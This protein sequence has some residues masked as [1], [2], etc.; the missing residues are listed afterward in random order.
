MTFKIKSGLQVGSTTVVDQNSYYQQ[1]ESLSTVS[2]SL[3]LDF[4]TKTLDKRISFTRASTATVVGPNKLVQYVT[5][6]TPRFD[7]DPLTGI[8]NGL[9]I[10]EQKTNYCDST[11]RGG[12]WSIGNV[13][14]YFGYPSP[15][16][17]YNAWRIKG[18]G[19]SAVKYLYKQVSYAANGNFTF[20]IYAKYVS[21]QY[22]FLRINDQT[23]GNGVIQQFDILNG[24]LVGSPSFGGSAPAATNGQ[25]AI[26]P[27][28]NGWY[29]L[30]V[31]CTMN[32]SPTVMQGSVFLNA[33]GST[34]VTTA[35]D[36]WAPQME[37]ALCATSYIPSTDTFT[38]RAS[39]A[40]YF[41]STDGLLKTAAINTSRPFFNPI[42]R[43]NTGLLIEGAMTNY[44]NTTEI[45]A[46]NN[47]AVTITSNAIA[48]PDGTLTADKMVEAAG[49][50]VGKQIFRSANNSAFATPGTWCTFSLFA[51]A[52]ERYKFQLDISDAVFTSADN[53]TF[54]L[55]AG[56]VTYNASGQYSADIIPYPNG[57]YRCSLTSKVVTATGGGMFLNMLDNAGNGTYT[58]DGTSGLYFW[59][60]QLENNQSPTSYIPATTTTYVTRSADVYASVS[61]TRA[62]EDVY[63][64]GTNFNTG[65]YNQNEGTI[66]AD[67]I[68]G[69]YSTNR[70]PGIV[71]LNSGYS[72]AYINR[73]DVR[74]QDPTYIASYISVNGINSSSVARTTN[75]AFKQRLKAA[76]AY[77]Q[78]DFAFAFSGNTTFAT[79]TS[80]NPPTVDRLQIGSIDGSNYHLDGWMRSIVYY[81]KR[82]TNTTINTILSQE[83]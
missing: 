25:S 59:G 68:E 75:Y 11:T 29:R 60:I 80:G 47:A 7:H 19:G 23:G 12:S 30:V 65:W 53:A 36:M 21:E 69:T 9:L 55:L 54:D 81:P 82:I 37:E 31:A 24:V 5:S 78:N 73:I 38:S 64:L 17:E 51:K 74:R 76:V 14:D 66:F 15:S 41:D 42:A 4:T 13:I 72:A 1:T 22:I 10:E 62:K 77:K 56:T 79:D 45:L 20:S 52:G 44:F 43:T 61:A 34:T 33:F 27:A 16:G 32:S 3:V 70:V 50:S 67:W 83:N 39:T 18:V 71:S 57:W 26:Y 63:I 40:T 2:P 6:S 46:G 58:G 28:G 48:A 35:F 49:T 8:C